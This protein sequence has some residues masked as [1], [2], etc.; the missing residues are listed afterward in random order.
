[1]GPTSLKVSVIVAVLDLRIEFS[2]ASFRGE[3]A[4]VGCEFNRRNGAEKSSR[5]VIK[6]LDVSTNVQPSALC[7]SCISKSCDRGKQ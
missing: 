3:I 1:M 5:S 2:S 6:W 4:I 7:R